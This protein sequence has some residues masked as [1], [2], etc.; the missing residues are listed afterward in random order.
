MLAY[1]AAVAGARVVV[2]AFWMH[3]LVCKDVAEAPEAVE[4]GTVVPDLDSFRLD[5]GFARPVH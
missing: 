1:F 4:V 2:F 3:L 5:V